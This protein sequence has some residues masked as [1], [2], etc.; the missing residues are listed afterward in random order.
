MGSDIRTK[1]SNSLDSSNNKI[2]LNSISSD[3]DSVD[4]N[5]SELIKVN[6]EDVIYSSNELEEVNKLSSSFEEEE[7]INNNVKDNS[8]GW[9]LG[10]IFGLGGD[11]N[12]HPPKKL[13]PAR[14]FNTIKAQMEI[15]KSEMKDIVEKEL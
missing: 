9:G 4:K 15:N 11:N 8:G 5:R 1:T 7:E 13:E 3:K 12:K 10:G 2:D 14:S 6:N